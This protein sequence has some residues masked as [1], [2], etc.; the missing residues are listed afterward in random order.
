MGLLVGIELKIRASRI[1]EAM[2]ARGVLTLTAGTT[3]LRLLPPLVI[4]PR[5]LDTVVEALYDSLIEVSSEG[6]GDES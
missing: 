3:V 6:A 2:T 5:E 4:G 1:V